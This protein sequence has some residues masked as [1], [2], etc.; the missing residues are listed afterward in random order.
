MTKSH[1]LIIIGAGPA[2]LT[3]ALYAGRAKLDVA[4]V[5]ENLP[6]GWMKTTHLVA[7]YPGVYPE[8]RGKELARLM[9]EQAK[10]YGVTFYNAAEITGLSLTERRKSVELDEE[11]TL[12]APAVILAMGQEPRQLGLP[13]EQTFKG[14]G[15][16]YCATCDADFYQDKQVVVVGG[17]NS[18]LEEAVFL[19]QFAQKVTIVHQFDGFQSSAL[20]VDNAQKNPKIEFMC[21]HEPRAYRGETKLEEVEVEDLKTGQRKHLATDGVFVYAGFV[22][23]TG[24]VKDQ[25]HL[26]DQGYIAADEL[27]HTSQPGVFAIGDVREKKYRQITTAVADGTIAALEAE[28]IIREVHDLVPGGKGA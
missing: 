4:V 18:A 17:G 27:M 28:K 12:Y 13:G 7:N 15:L 8:I 21:C 5:E 11:E 19:T 6:G 24:L 14:R 9:E 3:A 25:I 1:D 2:G 16:S 20:A 23:R 22:P 26:N 10:H